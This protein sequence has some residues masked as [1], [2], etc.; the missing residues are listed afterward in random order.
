MLLKSMCVPEYLYCIRIFSAEP[1]S[2]SAANVST[3]GQSQRAE[4]VLAVF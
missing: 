2:D 4:C 3:P 1:T